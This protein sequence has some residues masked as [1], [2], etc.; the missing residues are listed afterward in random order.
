M[1]LNILCTLVDKYIDIFCLFNKS[2]KNYLINRKKTIIFSFHAVFPEAI[3]WK[4]RKR[5]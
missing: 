5:S 4:G 3:A 2:L 1:F